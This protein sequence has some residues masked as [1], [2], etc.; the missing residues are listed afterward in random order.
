MNNILIATEAESL[1]SR[2]EELHKALDEI[3]TPNLS[4]IKEVSKRVHFADISTPQ[5]SYDNTGDVYY[6]LSLNDRGAKKYKN[7][8]LDYTI[9][10][11]AI[12]VF[13]GTFTKSIK[14]DKE[15]ITC[16]SDVFNSYAKFIADI[17]A[18]KI[19]Y[20]EEL[21]QFVKVHQN[22]YSVIDAVSFVNEYP[23]RKE[24]EI[25]DFLNVMISL[26]KDGHI[27][28]NHNYDIYTDYIA[29]NDWT[30]SLKLL[31]FAETQYEK[32]DIFPVKYDVDASEINTSL[33]KD[34]LNTITDS[35]SSVHNIK[36]IHAYVM[37][38]KLDFVPAEKWFLLKDFGRSGKGLLLESFEKLVNVRKVNYDAL[39]GNGFELAN[40]WINFYGADVAHANE[41]GEVTEKEM[42]VL[43]KIATGEN[44]T[45]RAIQKNS[46]SF[47]LEPV[48]ILDT[49]EHVDIGSM[50][51]NTSRT[52]K[53]SLKD[54]DKE[55]TDQQRHAAFK[56]FWDFIKP[57]GKHSTAAAVSF[58]IASLDYLSE[59]GG[60]FIFDDVTLK[61]YH[62][63]D[64]LTETQ[65]L[66]LEVINR[67]GYVLTS[68]ETFKKIVAEEYGS[69]RKKQFR[70]D[71]N[72]IGV[73]G[74]ISKKI[75]G[76]NYKVREIGNDN[77]FNL[78]Y[79]LTI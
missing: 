21:E 47:D 52:V 33:A 19:V 66:L 17:V 71:M 9:K 56:K 13:Y 53:I 65:Q 15:F 22:C 11:N 3:N 28:N 7:L 20:V 29:G 14:D 51:G 77:L 40:E 16:N 43:R 70:D 79:K 57:N 76:T 25:K 32:T 41:T 23:I 6:K 46:V 63:L 38:R 35:E 4:Q 18:N 26:F 67:Q 27:N 60:T 74:S 34:F 55:E 44:V 54:R 69:T 24:L 37:L 68:D 73:S 8:T 30:Y 39:T 72:K 78:A 50:T 12:G 31:T 75:D 58:L 48:L 42:R 2:H 5:Q 10:N 49:N 62:A 1:L 61:N 64:Q 45:G 59:I 36:L